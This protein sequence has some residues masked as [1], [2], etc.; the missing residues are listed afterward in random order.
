MSTKDLIKKIR[1][2]EIKTRGLSNHIFSGGYHT[3]FKGKGMIFSE[4]K[5]YILGDDIRNIDWNVTARFNS[6][7]V[8]TFEEERETTV[9]LLIDISNSNIFGSKQQLKKDLITEISAVL[10]FS[11]IQNNDKIGVIFFSETIEKYIPPKKGK[12]HIL[13]II[14]ELVSLK[15]NNKKTNIREAVNFFNSINK[16]RSICF[17]ISDFIDE[18]YIESISTANKKH[19][20]ICIKI[21]DYLEKKLPKIG[22]LSIIDP[23][24]GKI[25][26]I[27]SNKTKANNKKK[28]K[29]ELTKKGIDLI[30]LMT[31][32][33]YIK[34]LDNFFKK[35]SRKKWDVFI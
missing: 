27:N 9:I 6:P 28:L 13:R 26:I 34:K 18:N 31:N 17:I 7:Y 21:Q 35:R 30:E 19:D 2:I 16:K 3:A 8:K 33:S 25:S 11:A 12:K 24:T 4:V 23:E 1:K 32:E 22:L 29:L 14:H 20:I 10:A 5:D 15:P